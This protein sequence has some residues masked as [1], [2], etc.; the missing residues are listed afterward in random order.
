[1]RLATHSVVADTFSPSDSGATASHPAA[2][3]K[4]FLFH[5]DVIDGLPLSLSVA[6]ASLLLY[7]LELSDEIA[8]FRSFTAG[9]YCG[10]C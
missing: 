1:M 5:L 6:F 9:S 3:D 4:K 10:S 8:P 2:V 7:H